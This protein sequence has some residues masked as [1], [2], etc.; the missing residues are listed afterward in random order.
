MI[1]NSYVIILKEEFDLR[2]LKNPR[3]S[4]RAFSKYLNLTPTHVSM[5]LRGQR[6]LSHSTALKVSKK[7][8]WPLEKQ[9]YF[10]NL[11]E[12]ENPKSPENQEIARQNILKLES[13]NLKFNPLYVDNFEAISVWYYSA[14]LSLLTILKGQA[15][16][17][18]IAKKLR[19]SS[20][21]V[22]N[23]MTR[24][25]RLGLVKTEKKLW[26]GLFDYLRLKS[27]PSDA[28]KK[29]HKHILTL[30]ATSLDEQSFENR[31]FSNMTI[32]ID[33]TQ[34]KLAKAKIVDFHYEMAKLLEG[35][36][37]TEVYQLSVQLFQLT[38]PADISIS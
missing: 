31:D 24:L 38:D 11:L 23:A 27:V 29:Y 25:K 2:K 20:L 19:L 30:A 36:E 26:I 28:I 5:V 10:I 32:T 9:K 22:E 33:K 1:E 8:K 34:L 13:E 35:K 21:E 7:L 18:F 37:A 3:Y 6:H 15:T 4:L 17:S 14:I 12:F 16:T